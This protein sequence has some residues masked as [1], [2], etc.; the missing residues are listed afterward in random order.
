M[1]Y[2]LIAVLVAALVVTVV[3]AGRFGEGQRSGI[4]QGPLSIADPFFQLVVNEDA[5]TITVRALNALHLPPRLPAERATPGPLDLTFT[6]A[7]FSVEVRNEGYAA[8]DRRRA[9]RGPDIYTRDLLQGK[10]R[11]DRPALA[12][13]ERCTLVLRSRR[14]PL[15]AADTDA[16]R[17]IDEVRV[18]HL[19]RAD[20]ERLQP[21]LAQVAIWVAAMEA[22]LQDRVASHARERYLAR[23]K[24]DQQ[25]TALTQDRGFEPS[26]SAMDFDLNGRLHWA[27]QVDEGGHV[28]VLAD[29]QTFNGSLSGARVTRQRGG[30]ELTVRDL[31]WE[32]AHLARRRMLLFVGLDQATLTE[33]ETRIQ[34]LAAQAAQAQAADAG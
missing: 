32:T 28:W 23:A 10:A 33:W 6:A 29:G 7:G 17:E 11:P 24:A 30:L 31:P 13:S 22:A 18:E 2:L 15:A 21:Q 9:A 4:A 14:H 12:P 1:V 25:L 5:E 8:S 19:P 16:A 27:I 26:H 3:L 34:A 20:V